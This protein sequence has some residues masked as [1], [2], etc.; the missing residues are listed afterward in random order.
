MKTFDALFRL[1][2]RL[3]GALGNGANGGKLHVYPDDVFLV[4]YPKS[5]NT[6]LDFL[7]ACL[8]AE[9]PE[10]VNFESI[11]TCVADIYFN[12]AK[13]LQDLVRPRFL[14]S[15]ESFDAHYPKVVYI[16][17]DPRAVAVSYYH[18]LIGLGKIEKDFPLNQFVS[19]FIRGAVDGM[20]EW[21]EHVRGWLDAHRRNPDRV[22]IVKYED[23]KMEVVKT[24]TNIAAFLNMSVS[25]EKIQAAI[26]WSNPENMRRLELESRKSGNAGFSGFREGSFFVRKASSSDW[27]LE[28]GESLDAQI[29]TVWR[30]VMRDLGYVNDQVL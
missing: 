12:N 20:G 25:D 16:V 19:E 24:L 17:R 4:G 1:V 23:L 26:A 3:Y 8:R 22:M 18:Y 6:W 11:E 13:K 29:V 21:G 7:V 30:D 15:H 2:K 28:L 27:K 10:D 14:K 5:G 9:R